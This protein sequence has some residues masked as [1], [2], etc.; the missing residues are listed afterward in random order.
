MKFSK[1]NDISDILTCLKGQFRLMETC[2]IVNTE[3][4]ELI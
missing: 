4:Y 2:N 1:A 3:F